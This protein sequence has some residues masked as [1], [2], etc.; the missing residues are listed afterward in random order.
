MISDED[1]PFLIEN[2]RSILQYGNKEVQDRR[3]R[4]VHNVFDLTLNNLQLKEDS[5]RREIRRDIRDISFHDVPKPIQNNECHLERGSSSPLSNRFPSDVTITTNAFERFIKHSFLPKEKY[6]AKNFYSREYFKSSPEFTWDEDSS[7]FKENIKRKLFNDLI[8]YYNQLKLLHFDECLNY[9][10]FVNSH[11]R[12]ETCTGKKAQIFH[13][14]NV[15]KHVLRKD[16]NKNNACKN[17]TTFVNPNG[18]DKKR[19]SLIPIHANLNGNIKKYK[20]E[21]IMSNIN[22]EIPNEEFTNFIKK[23][24][25][26]QGKQFTPHLQCLGC[27][28]SYTESTERKCNNNKDLNKRNVDIKNEVRIKKCPPVYNDLVTSKVETIA[29]FPSID[30]NDNSKCRN[31]ND[32]IKCNLDIWCNERFDNNYKLD[33]AQPLNFPKGVKELNGFN[34]KK[35]TAKHGNEKRK[36]GKKLNVKKNHNNLKSNSNEH[37]SDTIQCDIE[38]NYSNIQ[39]I[40][41]SILVGTKR[42]KEIKTERNREKNKRHNSDKIELGS[43]NTHKSLN[44][45]H[46]KDFNMNSKH[47]CKSSII[48]SYTNNVYINT[49]NNDQIVHEKKTSHSN[50]ILE[51]RKKFSN[52]SRKKTMLNGQSKKKVFRKNK[53]KL[54]KYSTE[55][56]ETDGD[57]SFLNEKKKLEHEKLESKTNTDHLERGYLER[58]K[59]KKKNL[60]MEDIIE[61]SECYTHKKNSR[62]YERKNQV[63]MTSTMDDSNTSDNLKYNYKDDHG[64][65]CKKY[66]KYWSNGRKKRN[67]IKMEK[68]RL[69]MFHISKERFHL[70]R[71]AFSQRGQSDE[72]NRKLHTKH[73]SYKNINNYENKEYVSSDKCKEIHTNIAEWN[74]KNIVSTKLT[75]KRVIENKENYQHTIKRESIMSDCYVSHHGNLENR[76]NI[77]YNL[78][79]PT[80]K[81]N[82]DRVN[83]IQMN[84][85]GDNEFCEIVSVDTTQKYEKDKNLNSV[86]LSH[87][88]YM[89]R[90]K[91][92]SNFCN[93]MNNFN[94]SAIEEDYCDEID[95]KYLYPFCEET[96]TGEN[97]R[98]IIDSLKENIT[99]DNNNS[100]IYLKFQKSEQNSKKLLSDVLLYTKPLSSGMKIEPRGK[101]PLKRREYVCKHI[102]RILKKEKWDTE[103]EGMLN[104]FL[105]YVNLNGRCNKFGK[106]KIRNNVKRVKKEIRKSDR[107]NRGNVIIEGR[108]LEEQNTQVVNNGKGVDELEK[109]YLDQVPKSL[110]LT[111]LIIRNYKENARDADKNVKVRYQVE[112]TDVKNPKKLK[113]A[114]EKE[115]N[116]FS[117]IEKIYNFCDLDGTVD[118]EAYDNNIVNRYIPFPNMGKS[119]SKERHKNELTT[120]NYTSEKE[121]QRAFFYENTN[122]NNLKSRHL[123]KNNLTLYNEPLSITKKRG[124]NKKV[125]TF[126]NVSNLPKCNII[127]NNNSLKPNGAK[128]TFIKKIVPLKKTKHSIPFIFNKKISMNTCFKKISPFLHKSLERRTS[129]I[130]TSNVVSVKTKIA[131]K[132]DYPNRKEAKWESGNY[133]TKLKSYFANIRN[134]REVEKIKETPSQHE[135]ERGST[136]DTKLVS[137]LSKSFVIKIPGDIKKEQI[138]VKSFPLLAVEEF[139]MTKG[140]NWDNNH[141][142]E[143]YQYKQLKS[144]LKRNFKKIGSKK[145]EDFKRSSGHSN[146]KLDPLSR[147]EIG[148][149]NCNDNINEEN[150]EMKIYKNRTLFWKRGH[151]LNSFL[152]TNDMEECDLK[153][154]RHRKEIINTNKEPNAKKRNYYDNLSDSCK[155]D[156]KNCETF[157]N[158]SHWSDEKRGLM[159]KVPIKEEET[160]RNKTKESSNVFCE[161]EKENKSISR[162]VITQK[163]ETNGEL[164][165]TE[166]KK[167]NTK[168]KKESYID[169]KNEISFENFH[170]NVIKRFHK[171]TNKNMAGINKGE[172]DWENRREK[173]KQKLEIEDSSYI[174]HRSRA[175]VQKMTNTSR[176]GNNLRHKSEEVADEKKSHSM[177]KNGNKKKWN[178]NCD[179]LL[180]NNIIMNKDNNIESSIG[181][182]RKY[183]N[184][185]LRQNDEKNRVNFEKEIKENDT[186]DYVAS[187][188]S[189][190]Q[191]RINKLK[192][193]GNKNEN[194]LYSPSEKRY[195]TICSRKEVTEEENK[196]NN[197]MGLMGRDR[198]NRSNRRKSYD[199]YTRRCLFTDKNSE[200]ESNQSILKREKYT[201]KNSHYVDLRNIECSK[202]TLEFF[203]EKKYLK[204]NISSE[205]MD[206]TRKQEKKK[207][208]KKKDLSFFC[209]PSELSTQSKEEK[210]FVT[211]KMEVHK[212]IL[213]KK[214]EISKKEPEIY[215]FSIMNSREDNKKDLF[216]SPQ[217]LFIEKKKDRRKQKICSDKSIATDTSSYTHVAEKR[218]A[219]KFYEIKKTK[220]SRILDVNEKKKKKK[221]FNNYPITHKNKEKQY[222]RPSN[223]QTSKS[224]FSYKLKNIVRVKRNLYLSAND[225]VTDWSTDFEK[226]RKMD[227]SLEEQGNESFPDEQSEQV[228]ENVSKQMDEKNDQNID[229]ADEEQMREKVHQP[230]GEQMDVGTLVNIPNKALRKNPKLRHY[231]L[232]IKVNIITVFLHNSYVRRINMNDSYNIKLSIYSSSDIKTIEN[233][234]KIETFPCYFTSHTNGIGLSS[235]AFKK[236]DIICEREPKQFFKLVVSCRREKSLLKKELMRIYSRIFEAPIELET[237]SL[238]KN[239]KY[240]FETDGSKDELFEM[241]GNII[242]GTL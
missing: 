119:C 110:P 228:D 66:K 113:G 207:K 128:E 210:Q 106:I 198:I 206:T 38:N 133:A 175:T 75:P 237:Y 63:L 233:N 127:V 100:S 109:I 125:L 173:G 20:K 15:N 70:Q 4:Y 230:V 30:D 235:D 205:E 218:E 186:Q 102:C 8:D 86:T 56:F 50:D 161:V 116:L 154:N 134:S 171:F 2:L 95:K 226:L 99:S 48:F 140:E 77:K 169:R 170:P 72:E 1:S 239:K 156:K 166:Y 241:N 12:I 80:D 76:E 97:F 183:S 126:G 158:N 202:S 98:R 82:N 215:Y 147:E 71:N 91:R 176:G 5:R 114:M 46:R 220:T 192:K 219:L 137:Y 190:K 141:K 211:K 135:Q 167:E 31:R 229:K 231:F 197:T 23:S 54:K 185:S 204:K 115:T 121:E 138:I 160:Y 196:S 3:K 60:L 43:S 148:N 209:N 225:V 62:M 10:N 136:E 145:N 111:M 57:E 33:L 213:K 6:D 238:S 151:S 47:I 28:E 93:E 120:F 232:T 61:H 107:R 131:L 164:L 39:N 187:R 14:I 184:W 132:D 104:F 65:D 59:K 64:D 69:N 68:R 242:M 105:K 122:P 214:K 236:F 162:R 144:S 150:G 188:D 189:L 199:H 79:Y 44:S 193:M 123:S 26:A 108:K 195:I 174:W 24:T 55:S 124:V 58:E 153:E 53:I 223:I 74:I 32:I 17:V 240:A 200:T 168:I 234:C 152:H 191:H 222:K 37:F 155:M 87:N 194:M 9:G 49:N 45:K 7:S 41:G 42:N 29:S 35:N 81:H 149:K 203:L 101:L 181:S 18:N 19:D 89:N 227:C 90:G 142:T 179:L 34:I 117:R 180:K 96:Y 40:G 13:L 51:K 11:E 118:D 112:L 84:G 224:S 22:K 143:V 201:K 129:G 182:C 208:K 172:K 16:S 165:S 163:K 94:Y 212:K 52:H 130:N 221:N 217:K 103:A 73:R 92:Y 146:D 177:I 27:V 21:S 36:K 67:G 83:G 25:N 139:K 216:P 178:F 157:K 88:Y 78:F 85:I 159:K